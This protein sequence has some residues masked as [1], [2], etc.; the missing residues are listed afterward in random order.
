MNCCFDMCETCFDLIETIHCPH[1][2]QVMEGKNTDE[3]VTANGMRRGGARGVSGGTETQLG[4]WFFAGNA[5]LAFV[6]CYCGMFMHNQNYYYCLIAEGL[7]CMSL[8]GKH[9]R[10][11]SS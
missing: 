11:S 2:R 9:R 5:A 1:C 4:E 7:L 10:V 3:V 6:A 8:A